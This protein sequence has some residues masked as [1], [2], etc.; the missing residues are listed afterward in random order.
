M[1]TRRK[2]GTPNSLCGLRSCDIPVCTHNAASLSGQRRSANDCAGDALSFAHVTYLSFVSQKAS[3]CSSV[4]E[5]GVSM[6]APLGPQF[7]CMGIGKTEWS[8][9]T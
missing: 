1:P 5:G 2:L 9:E 6:H 7:C 8:F 3:H 4:P